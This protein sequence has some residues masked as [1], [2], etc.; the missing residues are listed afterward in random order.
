MR[1]LGGGC[2]DSTPLVEP[3][4][5]EVSDK[6]RRRNECRDAPTHDAAVG[7]SGQKK[8]RTKKTASSEENAEDDGGQQQEA[9]PA[10]KKKKMV[11]NVTP[12]GVE[13]DRL[14]GG[15]SAFQQSMWVYLPYHSCVWASFCV[16]DALLD[17]VRIYTEHV[18]A[19]PSLIVLVACHCSCGTLS[20]AECKS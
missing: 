7:G 20:G 18:H 16:A 10:K 2:D 4:E 1:H 15:D 17:N 14:S 6:R 9:L 13:D 11:A 12:L 3:E 5:L 8:K 19:H